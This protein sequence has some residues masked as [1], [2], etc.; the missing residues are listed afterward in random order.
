MQEIFGYKNYSIDEFGKVVNSKGVELKQMLTRR[1]YLYLTLYDGCGVG[2]QFRIHRLVAN[3]FIPVVEGKPHVNHMDGNKLNNHV[4]NLEWCTM[5]EN[6]AHYC[7]N[8]N[9]HVVTDDIVKYIRENMDTVGARGLAAQFNLQESYVYG[10]ANGIHWPN[11]HANLIREKRPSHPKP[12]TMF[13]TTGKFLKEYKSISEC[14]KD[15]GLKLSHVQRVITGERRNINGLVFRSE[16]VV[17]KGKT[18]ASV[19]LEKTRGRLIHKINDCGETV[20][21][22]DK[23]TD[24]A[25]SVGSSTQNVRRVL[26]GVQ[27]T[28]GG[29]VFKFA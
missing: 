17:K 3:N 19:T 10:V 26:S 12:V 5:R 14:A 28:A 9:G 15:N 23:L 20:T 13:S 11:V 21:V 25:K 22:F 16:G 2:K 7:K 24:A 4:S 6:I 27:K 29:F 8:K 18:K 1:G